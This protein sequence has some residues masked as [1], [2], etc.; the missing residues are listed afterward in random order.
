[1]ASVLIGAISHQL[2]LVADGYIQVAA[3]SISDLE[4]RVGFV[5]P[6][7]AL[8]LSDH[9]QALVLRQAYKECYNGAC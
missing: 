5:E 3:T 4:A 9:F 8:C 6:V 2:C 1:M 7:Q